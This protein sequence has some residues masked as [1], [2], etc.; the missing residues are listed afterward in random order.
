MIG[1]PAIGEAEHPHPEARPLQ[2]QR[3]E[4]F[5]LRGADADQPRFADAMPTDGGEPGVDPLPRLEQVA[6]TVAF[7]AIPIIGS[8]G[9]R[10]VNGDVDIAELQRAAPDD[11]PLRQA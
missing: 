10:A 9:Q 8:V 2:R 5:P 4:Q 6:G 7:Q 1:Q 11:A 3:Q